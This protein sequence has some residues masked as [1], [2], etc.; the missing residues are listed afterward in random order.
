MYSKLFWKKT[1]ENAVVTFLQFAL[2]LVPANWMTIQID[3]TP[4]LIFCV[5]G[6]VLA[7]AKA[8][9]AGLKNGTTS[10]IDAPLIPPTSK[11]RHSL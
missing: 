7:F 3:W 9:L 11:G 6:F 8:M 5:I 4:I 2:V 10:L 1:F